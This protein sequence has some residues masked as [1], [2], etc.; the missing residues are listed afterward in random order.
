MRAQEAAARAMGEPVNPWMM[1]TGSF[2]LWGALFALALILTLRHGRL[3]LFALMLIAGTSGF[4]QE[5]F[6]DCDK[7]AEG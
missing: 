6:G 5:F 2:Y 7:E 1:E 3:P 4:W